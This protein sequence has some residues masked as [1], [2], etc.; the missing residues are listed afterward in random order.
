MKTNVVRVVVG[1]LL[2]AACPLVHAGDW[3]NSG[4]NPLR[5]GLSDE[6]G[7]ASREVLW[8]GT[9]PGIFGLPVFISGDKLVTARFQS[10]DY[11]PIVCHDLATGET[12]WTRDFPGTNSRSIPIGF[13]DGRVYAINFQESQHD[14]LYA[15]DANDGS[16]LWRG[17]VQTWMSITES[18]TFC[19]N[20]DLLVTAPNFRIARV[21]SAI[22]DTVWT[23]RRVW[24]VTGSTDICVS[25]NRA[26]AYG[27]DIGSFYLIAIDLAT[28]TWKDTIRIPDTHPGGP[29]PQAAPMVGPDGTIYAH[30][31]GDNVT[32]VRDFGDSLGILWIAEVSGDNGMYSAFAHFAVGPDSTVYVGSQGCVVRLD[33]HTG[34][35]I[36]TSPVI[37]DL[38]YTFSLRLAID[39][40]GR[41]YASN[42]GVSPSGI[43]VFTPDLQLLWADTLSNINTSGPAIGPGGVMAVAAA[44]TALKV[45][46]GSSGIHAPDRPGPGLLSA[47]PNPFRNRTRVAFA[48]TAAAGPDARVTICDIT[49]RTVRTLRDQG[50]LVWDGTDESGS[51]LPAGIYICRAGRAG[52]S[53]HLV[54]LD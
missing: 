42:G 43:F 40:Q 53:L 18:A 45:Y 7:P 28:G 1:S 3:T 36:D 9:I 52:A 46:R 54:K 26:Y 20:G 50:P 12:L 25:G 27:G 16:I 34:I 22:G 15:L 37:Q 24:P 33:Q 38:R 41:V 2:A 4:G 21:N 5:S 14:T 10:I 32:A 51:V 17:Q 47:R 49:G 8:Q 44:G 23:T 11:T 29:M 30:K 13:R 19:D 35:G 39:R 31:V 48:P 6:S